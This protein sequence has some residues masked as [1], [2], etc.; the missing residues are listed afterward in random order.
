MQLAR[1]GPV[2]FEE[3]VL[4]QSAVIAGIAFDQQRRGALIAN[5]AIA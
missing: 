5:N 2:N 1:T 3:K 4:W